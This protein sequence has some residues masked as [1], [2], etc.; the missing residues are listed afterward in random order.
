MKDIGILNEIKRLKSLADVGLLYCKNEYDKE[1][2][3]ELQQISLNLFAEVSGTSR[4]DLTCIFPPAKD[5][6]TAKVDIRGV[7]ISAD[8]KILLVQESVDGKWSLPGGWADIGFSPKETIIKE[9]K[10]ETGLDVIPDRLLAVFDKK[11]HPHPPQP[12]YVYKMVFYCRELTTEITKGFDVLDVDYFAFDNLPTLSEDR[13]L[14]SQIKLLVTKVLE[15]D[16]E[17]YVD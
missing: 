12:F 9:C 2:Y 5:Y 16:Y 13:I 15:D 10:E 8:K 4:E 11:M 14:S 3:L 7:M 17:V 1:R 6:P